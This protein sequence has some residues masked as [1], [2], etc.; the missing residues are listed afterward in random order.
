MA[1]LRK[2]E[3]TK[4]VGKLVDAYWE[5]LRNAPKMGKKVAWTCGPP[6]SQI[7]FASQGMAFHYAE[8]FG[9]YVA[10]RHMQAPFLKAND[11]L[12]YAA[13]VC[14]YEKISFG[15]IQLSRT[16]EMKNIDPKYD[17]PTPDFAFTA[18]CCPNHATFVDAVGRTYGIPTVQIDVPYAYEPASAYAESVAY[19]KRQILEVIVPFVE[20]MLGKKYDFDAL[21]Q[22]MANLQKTVA[23]RHEFMEAGKVHPAPMTFFDAMLSIAMVVTLAGRPEATAYSEKLKVEVDERIKNKIG[24]LSEERHRVYFDHIPI[25]YN[26]S[27]LSKKLADNGI[28]IVCANYTHGEGFPRYPETFDPKTPVDSMADFLVRNNRCALPH[29]KLQWAV[30]AAREYECDGAMFHNNRTCRYFAVDQLECAKEMERKLGIPTVIFDG[31]TCDPQFLSQ[32]QLESRLDAWIEQLE[33]RKANLKE[34]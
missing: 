1:T 11:D 10:G 3:T 29:Y 14:G 20:K 7:L 26:I 34:V 23:L 4:M 12:G 13:D 28:N 8:P 33:T 30:D 16:G 31:D 5:E 19:V 18:R 27:Y 24:A 25:W 2:L 15:H 17:L 9:A 21:S 22:W 32:A 6:S